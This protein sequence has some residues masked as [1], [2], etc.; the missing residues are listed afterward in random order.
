[1]KYKIAGEVNG[2]GFDVLLHTILQELKSEN[3]EFKIDVF[4]EH[5]VQIATA[6][7]D[8]SGTTIELDELSLTEQFKQANK[9]TP[10]IIVRQK[11][12]ILNELQQSLLQLNLEIKKQAKLVAEQLTRYS[13][14]FMYYPIEVSEPHQFIH[15]NK[16]Y[17]KVFDAFLPVFSQRNTI[18]FQAVLRGLYEKLL[19]QDKAR[20]SSLIDEKQREAIISQYDESIAGEQEKIV[21]FLSK[22]QNLPMLVFLASEL[23]KFAPVAEAWEGHKNNSAAESAIKTKVS[24]EAFNKR[25]QKELDEISNDNE[26][27]QAFARNTLGSYIKQFPEQ[28]KEG[29]RLEIPDQFLKHTGMR[30]RII[31]LLFQTELNINI[32]EP[33][34]QPTL[35]QVV[36]LINNESLINDPVLMDLYAHEEMAQYSRIK[37]KQDF[38][39]NNL[40]YLVLDKF[41]L[42]ESTFEN[43]NLANSTLTHCHFFNT[44]FKNA[45][46]INADLRESKF[47]FADFSGADLSGANLQGAELYN[48]K[49][50]RAVLSEKTVI[51]WNEYG[52]DIILSQ[53]KAIGKATDLNTAQQKA[54]AKE[55]INLILPKINSNKSLLKLV[56]LIEGK[57]K[58]FAYLREEQAMW[59]FNQYGNTKT[60]ST[61]IGQIKGQFD[62]NVDAESKKKPE[63]RE[64]YTGE[65]YKSFLKIM[66][67]HRGRG[68]G[69]VSHSKLYEHFSE[70]ELNDKDSISISKK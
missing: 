18:E 14:L 3:K 22:Q 58:D 47:N 6:I 65:E 44:S 31:K 57:H 41:H 27:L 35:Q 60:W 2:L 59:R 5:D 54:K 10:D 42:N 51:D 34:K 7:I 46:L 33:I 40:S 38:K 13:E 1:M 36:A 8:I 68:F 63:D 52:A 69:T 19:E 70:Q 11:G 43:A 20:A 45:A 17:K 16:E 53:L 30:Q 26:R 4:D 67:E 12:I 23:P 62:R 28:Y 55:C 21:A 25:K 39:G 24:D 32:L 66:D 49:W 56:E 64:T 50:G 9:D 29:T 15:E 37:R 48:V 61:I